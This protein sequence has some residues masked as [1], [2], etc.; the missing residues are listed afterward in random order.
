[1]SIRG[2]VACYTLAHANAV[3]DWHIYTDLALV[4]IQQARG[5]RRVKN[6]PCYWGKRS[7]R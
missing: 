3:H 1:M 5:C 6:W 7:M 2:G 4:L